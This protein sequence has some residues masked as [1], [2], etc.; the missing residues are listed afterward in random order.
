M[1]DFPRLFRVE[2]QPR[3]ENATSRI[4]GFFGSI[5]LSRL[6]ARGAARLETDRISR[7]LFTQLL[8]RDATSDYLVP[9]RCAVGRA[10]VDVFTAGFVCVSF[11]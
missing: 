5:S 11:V 9:P 6:G 1:E 7:E 3:E 4:G 2:I 8:A 10:D